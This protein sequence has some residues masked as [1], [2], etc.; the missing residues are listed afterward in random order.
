[1]SECLGSDGLWQMLEARVEEQRPPEVLEVRPSFF[2]AKDCR[3]HIMRAFM[4]GPRNAAQATRIAA[5]F[6]APLAA[7][8][9]SAVM[10]AASAAAAVESRGVATTSGTDS[11]G[12]LI[13]NKRR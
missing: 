13:G 12:G 7:A 3:L 1:M 6:S 9:P 5:S 4:P 11:L 8:A 10:A 2:R